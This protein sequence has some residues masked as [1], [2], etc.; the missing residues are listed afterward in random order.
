MKCKNCG[1]ELAFETC[2]RKWLHLW[3]EE[4][5]SLVEKI[6]PEGCCNPQPLDKKG[7]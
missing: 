6:S 5:V 2:E 4:G 7:D 3:K 1:Y